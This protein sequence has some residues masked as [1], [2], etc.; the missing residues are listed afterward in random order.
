MAVNYHKFLHLKSCQEWQLIRA[1]D[2]IGFG[3]IVHLRHSENG[4]NRKYITQTLYHEK[5]TS[6]IANPSL[7][8]YF[9]YE[10]DPAKNFGPIKITLQTKSFI[11]IYCDKIITLLHLY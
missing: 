8:H 1:S 6:S 2:L 11:V 4:N 9:S 7:L 5:K 3:N 10:P